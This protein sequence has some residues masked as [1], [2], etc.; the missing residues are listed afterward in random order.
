MRLIYFG[1]LYDMFAAIFWYKYNAYP[2]TVNLNVFFF[3]CDI[4]SSHAV[5]SNLKSGTRQLV[6]F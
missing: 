1:T 3:F 5:E 6:C 2:E 4:N